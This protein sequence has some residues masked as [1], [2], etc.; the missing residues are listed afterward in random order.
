MGRFCLI[1][2]R[3]RQL[4]CCK[5]SASNFRSFSAH[6]EGKQECSQT[7]LST[8]CIPQSWGNFKLGD[9]PKP[10]AEGK[11]LCTSLLLDDLVGRPVTILRE[12]HDG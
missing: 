1:R 11:P 12:N 6:S 3:R 7:L 9:T 4:L 2:L 10:L 5:L 8:P